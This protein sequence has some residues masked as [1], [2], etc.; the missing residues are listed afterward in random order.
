MNFTLFRIVLTA[1]LLAVT[2]PGFNALADSN[3]EAIDKAVNHKDRP[4]ADRERDEWR[5]PAATLDFFGVRGDMNMIELWPGGGWYT[6][7]LGPLTS[8]HGQMTA[9]IFTTEDRPPF[10][11]RILRNYL[12][13]L[14]D[15]PALNHIQ[16][17]VL[18]RGEY[19]I[20]QAGSA[21][22]VLTF[23]NVHS[24]MRRGILSEV[25]NV[26]YASLKPGGIFGVV[27]HRGNEGMTEE[28]MKNT[29]YVPE[30]YLIQ[31]AQKA[32]FVL[33]EKSEINANPKDSKDHPMG[34]WTLPPSLRLKDKDRQK[35]LDI[36]ESDRFTL[37]FIKF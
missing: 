1:C 16:T 15:K 24:W 33:L 36:G 7:I 13:M 6:K 22:M 8:P 12:K 11:R 21:D 18:D 17:A 32:G 9:A 10:Y 27:G 26:S 28:Q 34:V 19:D 31:Q 29:G 5:H 20:A 25:L 3:K 30:Q 2:V 35:Y 23:R 4:T 37:K 14:R